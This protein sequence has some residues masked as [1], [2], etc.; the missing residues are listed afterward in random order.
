MSRRSL[1]LTRHQ[2]QSQSQ[3]QGQ[4]HLLQRD[5]KLFHQYKIL[6]FTRANGW[7]S[8][9]LSGIFAARSSSTTNKSKTVVA[10]IRSSHVILNHISI[11]KFQKRADYEENKI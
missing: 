4:S 10:R 2:S 1:A 9:P 3:S 5:S 7:A 6:T 11:V 8:T